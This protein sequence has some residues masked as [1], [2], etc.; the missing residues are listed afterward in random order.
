MS[1]SD[2]NA[3]DP[4]DQFTE[5]LSALLAR[6]ALCARPNPDLARRVR[7]S[8]TSAETPRRTHRAFA[9][10]LPSLAPI[11]SVALVALLL[12]AFVGMLIGH[13]KSGLPWQGNRGTGASASPVA[14]QIPLSPC[15]A[16]S[17]NSTGQSTYPSIALAPNPVDHS[18]VV[19][20]SASDKGITVTVDRAY[21]DAT[22]TVLVYHTSSNSGYM[23]LD[24]RLLDA[25]GASYV[26]FASTA[27]QSAR[28]NQSMV[29]FTPLPQSA[30]GSPQRLTLHITNLM[31]PGN[32][33]APNPTVK[34]VWDIPFTITPVAGTAI[35]LSLPPQTHDGIT[36][37]VE[38]LDVAP[39]GGG[40]DGQ[41]GGVRVRYRIS[42][43]PPSASLMR[44]MQYPQRF[45][46]VN[47]AASSNGAP[48]HNLFTLKLANG[49]ETVPGWIWPTGPIESS[50]LHTQTVGAS[51]SAEFEA[52]FFA[53]MSPG[54][55]T[56][57]I[58]TVPIGEVRSGQPVLR[59]AQG[60][61]IFMA[62]L[63]P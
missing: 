12:V 59:E 5:Q 27:S 54:D 35:L 26:P 41:S 34:G 47:S 32:I 9:V 11:G 7:Y 53:P 46:T 57:S 51:G 30:L 17:Q 49:Q 15:A 55:A 58:N 39:A 31:A 60:Q 62:P 1:P 3:T 25:S 2:R 20:A 23:T 13:G 8:L 45:T 38:E 10:R 44:A 18:V 29:V 33:G 48:C 6:T 56:I 61:W 50:G 37:Q 40:L 19:G 16:N 42:N 14:T 28:H 36:I 52:L 24:P 4:Q 22:Q 63:K 21:A 43:L